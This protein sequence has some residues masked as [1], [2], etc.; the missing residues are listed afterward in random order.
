MT[1]DQLRSALIDAHRRQDWELAKAL[2]AARGI[3]KRLERKERRCLDCGLKVNPGATRCF[4]H[5]MMHRN[6]RKVV[7]RIVGPRPR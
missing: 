6:G 3:L 7:R 4:L 2:S 1:Q 5:Y